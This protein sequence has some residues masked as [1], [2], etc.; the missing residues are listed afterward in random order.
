M[1]REGGSNREGGREARREG[2]GGAF[3]S[4]LEPEGRGRRERKRRRNQR[5]K[6][7]ERE[8]GEG[9]KG[10]RKEGR[11]KKVVGGRVQQRDGERKNDRPISHSAKGS[12]RATWER[13]RQTD[14]TGDSERES[15]R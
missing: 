11:E 9:T 2:G 8:R 15:E 3:V 4:D 6:E 14:H 5:E 12:P 10:K 13:P 1:G 7:G